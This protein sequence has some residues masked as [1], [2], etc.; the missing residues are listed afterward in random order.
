MASSGLGPR[1]HPQIMA[2]PYPSLGPT[3][4]T[5]LD[6]HQAQFGTHWQPLPQALVLTVSDG[7]IAPSGGGAGAGATQGGAS[8]LMTGR[9]PEGTSDMEISDDDRPLPSSISS[10]I[11]THPPPHQEAHDFLSSLFLEPEEEGVWPG[12][13]TVDAEGAGVCSGARPVDAAGVHAEERTCERTCSSVE[14][15]EY[16]VL[17]RP[18]A[19]W[20]QDLCPV[21]RP[22]SLSLAGVHALLLECTH[23]F[24]IAPVHPPFFSSA[25][26][27][28]LAHPPSV[29]VYP[30]SRW[31]ICLSFR[32]RF[33]SLY[34]AL[35]AASA[36]T[37][38]SYAAALKRSRPAHS[39]LAKFCP[40][41]VLQVTHNLQYCKR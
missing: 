1:Q 24:R 16:K 31:R 39:A 12:D 14:Q 6:L 17:G 18:L 15:S 21:S 36:L 29:R 41:V 20:Y 3:T 34:G 37:R 2:V 40:A 19:P 23:S 30:L 26:T 35:A 5:T 9:V 8:V 28:P 13:G 33:L 22:S 11:Q 38:P 27:F 10:C 4:P 32:V 25:L 7:D